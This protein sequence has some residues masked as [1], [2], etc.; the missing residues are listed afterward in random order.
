MYSLEFLASKLDGFVKGDATVEIA[1]IATLS[2]AGESDISFCTNPKYLK[3][4][5]GTKASAVL[6]TEE[7]LE[8]L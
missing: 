7:A 2:Q 4:L 3:Q 5:S 8:Y 6:I 1:K